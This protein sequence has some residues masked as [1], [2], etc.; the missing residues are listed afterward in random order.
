MRDCD[1]IRLRLTRPPLSL[2]N[3]YYFVRDTMHIA[4]YPKSHELTIHVT[5]GYGP[6]TRVGFPGD[7]GA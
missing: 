6:Y 3:C 5:V 4:Q 7:W 1:A 2:T